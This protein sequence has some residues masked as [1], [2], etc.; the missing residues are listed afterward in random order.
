MLQAAAAAKKAG[1]KAL[2]LDVTKHGFFKGRCDPR[3]V[4]MEPGAYD[5][6]PPTSG[7]TTSQPSLA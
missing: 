7:S 2:V 1:G 5:V 3:T 4:A 6:E